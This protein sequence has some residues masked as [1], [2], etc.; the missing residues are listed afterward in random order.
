MDEQ[1]DVAQLEHEWVSSHKAKVTVR[2]RGDPVFIHTL[3]PANATQRLRFI[4]ELQA[5][6]PAVDAKAIDTELLRIADTTRNPTN[7]APAVECQ[8][9]ADLL[10]GMPTDIVQEAKEM[11]SDPYLISRIADDVAALGV[12]GEPELA[13]TLYLIG[14]SRL[15]DKPLSGIVMGPSS[16]GKSHANEKVARLFPPET[17]IPAT[18]MTPQALFHMKPGSLSHKFVVAG[19]RSRI[20]DDERAEATRALR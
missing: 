13:V 10:A 9:S 3:D 15:L 4:K 11:L 1:P 14:T 16:S 12:A 2:W 18:Q 19:E 20:E 5:K 17:I 7:S 8:E 6:V